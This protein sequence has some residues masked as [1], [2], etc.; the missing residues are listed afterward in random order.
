[1]APAQ[2]L[3]EESHNE[4]IGFRAFRVDQS[5]D[6]VKVGMERLTMADLDDGD[7]VVRVS[8]S[9]VNYKDA[10]AARGIGRNV[11]SDRPCVTGI[12]LA[13]TVVSSRNPEFEPGDRIIATNYALGVDHD[14]GYAEYARIPSAWAVPLPEGLTPCEAMALGTAGLTA[15]LA[16]D[17]FERAGLRPEDGSVAVTGATGGVGSL[18]ISMLGQRGHEVV[19]ISRKE[20]EAAYL[21][22]IGAASVMDPGAL[23]TA[24]RMLADRRWAAAIDGVGG[25]LLSALLKHMREHGMVAVC[26]MVADPR[27]EATVYP[28]IMRAID[29]FGINVSRTL[30]MQERI[31]LWTRLASDLKPTALHDMVEIITLDDLD[32]T[33][34]RFLGASVRGRVVVR[35]CE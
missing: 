9:S 30:P 14:G 1:M 29:M 10:M 12:D 4:G 7:L 35:I 26:G 13:G 15:A 27:F 5:G 11:R 20:S 23:A 32:R 17:R 22:S 33:F 3:V 25:A 21:R 34:D 6:R 18:A 16:I 31:R 28:F 24:D 19:A 2:N 8:F